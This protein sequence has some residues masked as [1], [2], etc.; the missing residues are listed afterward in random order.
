[1]RTVRAFAAGVVGAVAVLGGCQAS[2]IG[3]EPIARPET[4]QAPSYQEVAER[5][6]ERAQHF[7]RLWA[8]T[9]VRLRY[10]DEE[11]R[12]QTEQGD[13]G[14]LM[15]V[16]PDHV[17]LS[18]GKLGEPFFRLGSNG[19]R[20]WWFDLRKPRRAWVGTH[21]AAAIRRAAAEESPIPV[22]PRDLIELLGITLLP[23]E[24]AGR[25][26]WTA[27]QNGLVV[28]VPSEAGSRRLTLDPQTY[29]PRAIELFDAS[30][31][32]IIRSELTQYRP[33]VVVGTATRPRLPTYVVVSGRG[34]EG[35][36]RLTI[37]DAENRP[38]KPDPSDP[39]FDFERL[40]RAHNV[41][42]ENITVLGEG[43]AQPRLSEHR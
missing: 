27:D 34:D 4:P 25:V 32:P 7:D 18:T 24:A 30:G 26:A 20:F 14:H 29:E 3:G 6:N 8:R 10:L 19:E 16:R 28:D 12:W 2:P 37:A 11:G 31:T 1:M 38:G 9:T 22:P 17:A 21:D 23:T 33:F 13:D 5:Y 40:V 39:V 43:D 41:A 42:P 15:L 35:E 36:L